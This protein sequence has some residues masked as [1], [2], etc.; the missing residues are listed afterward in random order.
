MELNDPKRKKLREQFEVDHGMSAK[1]KIDPAIVKAP[2]LSYAHRYTH[3]LE[4]K[5]IDLQAKLKA[6]RDRLPAAE[7]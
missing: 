7:K 5:V 2:F 1:I 4:E 3:A 6:I